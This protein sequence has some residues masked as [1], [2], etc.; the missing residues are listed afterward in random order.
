MCQGV[1]SQDICSELNRVRPEARF[2]YLDETFGEIVINKDGRF[3]INP[4][5]SKSK[6]TSLRLDNYCL[7]TGMQPSVNG[8]ISIT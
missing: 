6:V 1:W 7:L 4:N 2:E 8:G 3:I 5:H